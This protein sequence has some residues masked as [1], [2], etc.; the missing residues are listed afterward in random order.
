ML[1]TASDFLYSGTLQLC[2]QGREDG[3]EGA[4]Q[5]TPGSFHSQDFQKRQSGYSS[6]LGGSI[7]NTGFYWQRYLEFSRAKLVKKSDMRRWV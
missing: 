5:R 7:P 6:L 1:R 2:L 4:K 3:F